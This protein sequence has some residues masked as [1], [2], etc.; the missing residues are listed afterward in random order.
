MTPGS[1]LTSGSCQAR[2][3]R[4][5]LESTPRLRERPR[6]PMGWKLVF[7]FSASGSPEWGGVATAPGDVRQRRTEP[8]GDDRHHTRKPPR[9]RRNLGTDARAEWRSALPAGIGSPLPTYTL[10]IAAFRHPLRGLGNVWRGFCTPGPVR[11]R[12]PMA[13]ADG[14]HPGLPL[15]RPLRG[16]RGAGV[17]FAPSGGATR[18]SPSS[19]VDDSRKAREAGKGIGAGGDT[20]SI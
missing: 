6:K 14:L 13:D 7:P 2:A 4:L 18:A 15:H 20:S 3:T 1:C 17:C 9:G 5:G 12:P 11:H 16:F 8:G 10:R 19:G